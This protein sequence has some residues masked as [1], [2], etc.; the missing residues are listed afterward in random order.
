MNNY[1]ARLTRGLIS[2]VNDN[3]VDNTLKEILVYIYLVSIV[4]PKKG[5]L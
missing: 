3:H 5:L 1:L 2:L 4:K